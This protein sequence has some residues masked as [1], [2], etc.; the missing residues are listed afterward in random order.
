VVEQCHSW[1]ATADDGQKPVFQ[2]HLWE[3]GAAT[4]SGF[5]LQFEMIRQN[6]VKQPLVLL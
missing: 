5:S 6:A 4:Q 1:S 3:I 2:Q